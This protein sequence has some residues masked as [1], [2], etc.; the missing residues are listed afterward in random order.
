MQ[1]R[2]QKKTEEIN[3]I[4]TIETQILKT[5]ATSVNYKPTHASKE[6]KSV[7]D[8]CRRKCRNSH[9]QIEEEDWKLHLKKLEVLSL[10]WFYRRQKRAKIEVEGKHRQRRKGKTTISLSKETPD[11]ISLWLARNSRGCLCPFPIW[12]SQLFEIN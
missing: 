1:L 11:F 3:S 10:R 4:Q 2:F 6:D 12:K 9:Q 7:R 5:T 8:L